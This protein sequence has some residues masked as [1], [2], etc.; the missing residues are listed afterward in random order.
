MFI[1]VNLGIYINISSHYIYLCNLLKSLWI[2]CHK[3]ARMKCSKLN[4][5]ILYKNNFI[6][7]NNNLKNKNL[8][9]HNSG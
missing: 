7:K 3:T 5:N 6:N 1:W 2:S 8:I 4:K 9:S